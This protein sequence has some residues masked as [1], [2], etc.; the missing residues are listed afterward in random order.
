MEP[1]INKENKENSFSKKLN[2]LKGV[3]LTVFSFVVAV[4]V[5]KELNSN[6]SKSIPTSEPNHALEVQEALDSLN[7]SIDKLDQILNEGMDGS[8]QELKYK[9]QGK[10]NKDKKNEEDNGP[11]IYRGSDVRNLC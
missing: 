5:V 2:L 11:A 9:E 8:N 1:I 3:S 10:D 7:E 6:D 4:S